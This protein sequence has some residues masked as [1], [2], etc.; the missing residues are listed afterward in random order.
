MQR[1]LMAVAVAGV[2]AAPALVHAQASNVQIYGRIT[3]EYGY[4]TK[5][6]DDSSGLSREKTDVASTPGGAS[7]GFRGE[8]KLGGGL[9]AWFQCESSADV[10][11]RNNTGFCSRNSAI[12]FK[13]KWG[14]LHFGRWDTPFKRTMRGNAGMKASGLLGLLSCFLATRLARPLLLMIKTEM[15]GSAV[16]RPRRIT[17]ARSSAASRFLRPSARVTTPRTRALA[18]PILSR[19]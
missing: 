12:G 16:S 1:K 11:G 19:G 9:T 17:R 4:V 10:R 18:Q 2:F 13:G 15:S 5:M 7:L 6:G 8:E 3:Y 14:N